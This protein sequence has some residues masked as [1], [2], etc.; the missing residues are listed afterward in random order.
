MPPPP[1]R[2]EKDRREREGEREGE[3]QKGER[4]KGEEEPGSSADAR[5]MGTSYPV[6]AYVEGSTIHMPITV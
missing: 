4:R 6:L 2:E 1:G 3:E 5:V